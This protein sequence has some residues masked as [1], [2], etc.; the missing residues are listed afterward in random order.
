[1]NEFIV[2]INNRKHLVKILGDGKVQVGN[3]EVKTDLSQISNNSYVIR[4]DNSVFEITSNKLNSDRFGIVIDACYFDTVVRT[5]LQETANDLQK[6]QSKLKH[7]SDVK[8]PMPGLILKFK[9]KVGEEIRIGESIL[10]LEAMKMENE[11]RSPASGILKQIFFNEGQS[12]EK[13][14][15]ILT[16]E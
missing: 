11:L 7:H 2:T 10:I 16:I 9:K 13:D 6:K 1:M 8:A 5:Q 12:V 15:I 14:S 4:I 3:R